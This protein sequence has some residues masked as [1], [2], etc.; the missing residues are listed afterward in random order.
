M[1]WSSDGV[2]SR[3]AAGWISRT[4]KYEPDTSAPSPDSV[5]SP[6]AMFAPNSTCAA[7]PLSPVFAFSRS[8]NIG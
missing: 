5:W 1:V 8:R 2:K 6:Y 4:G 3:P 7:S